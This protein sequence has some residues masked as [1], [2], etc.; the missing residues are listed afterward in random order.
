MSPSGGSTYVRILY[1]YDT[2]T[3]LSGVGLILIYLSLFS[4][5]FGDTGNTR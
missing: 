3:G 1:M 2:G 4:P 5:L